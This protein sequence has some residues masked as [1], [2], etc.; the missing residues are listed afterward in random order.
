MNPHAE[1]RKA[2]AEL[3]RLETESERLHAE[4]V[5]VPNSEKD[6]T[7]R[8]LQTQLAERDARI[9]TLEAHT[10]R[11]EDHDD[12]FLDAVREFVPRSEWPRLALA[13]RRALK[14]AAGE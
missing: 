12:A 8:D 14:S 13:A 2:K 10:R 5:V 3:A 6:R 1:L 9:E 11:L 7:I 4:L